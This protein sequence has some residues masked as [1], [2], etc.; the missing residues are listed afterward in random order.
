MV[1]KRRFIIFAPTKAEGEAAYPDA[2]VVVTPRSPDAARGKVADR[3]LVMDSMRDHEQLAEL[4]EAAA[5]SL[6]TTGRARPVFVSGQ[7]GHVEAQAEVEAEG[8]DE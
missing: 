3:V 5:P 2:E 7:L 1:R 4:L 8:D 6:E